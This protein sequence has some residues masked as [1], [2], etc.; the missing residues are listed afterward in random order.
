MQNC[1]TSDTGSLTAQNIGKLVALNFGYDHDYC[2]VYVLEDHT[3]KISD[4]VSKL[5]NDIQEMLNK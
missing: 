2:E 3:K 4:Y 5:E 1:T